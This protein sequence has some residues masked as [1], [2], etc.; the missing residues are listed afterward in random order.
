MSSVIIKQVAVYHPELIKSNDEVAESFENKDHL[1][2]MWK[3][4]GRDKRF[5]ASEEENTLTMSI[6]AARKVLAASGLTGNDIDLIVVS[7]GTHE[8]SI[9]TD[10]AFVHKAIEGKNSC[11]IYDSNANCVGMVVAYDQI[12]RAM[13]HN[14]K[15]KYGLLVGS[16][17]VG[18]FYNPGDIASEGLSG[19]A[20]CAVLLE[21]IEEDS[22]GLIDSEYFT[23]TDKP[24][25]L[26]LP[27]KGFSKVITESLD[28]KIALS[29]DYNVNIAFP[30]AVQLINKLLDDHGYKK[31][32]VSAYFVSQL[33]LTEIHKLADHLEEDISKFPYIGDRYA[34]TGTSSPFIALYHAMEDGA[35]SQG[36]V[37][38]MWSVGSGITSCGVLGRL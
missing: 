28:G 34:Y 24:E 14:P 30:A 13:A 23:S 19:D 9:P 32:D 15:M 26:M 27:G 38:V 31:S 22:A 10:A 18:R 4:L 16:E 21:R 25:G 7:S 3:H 36:D 6:E 1:V 11:A 17:Q 35:I 5:I 20:A 2:G 29:D 8:Y 37:F 12:S 33:F